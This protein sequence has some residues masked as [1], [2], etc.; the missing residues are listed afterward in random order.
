MQVFETIKATGDELHD[1]RLVGLAPRLEVTDGG[2]I[3]DPN[4]SRP[5]IFRSRLTLTADQRKHSGLR[6]ASFYVDRDL[7]GICQPGDRLHI[8]RTACGGLGL[9]LLR[10]DQLVVAVGAIAKVPLGNE[11][12]IET[13]HQRV[14]EAESI[15]RRDDP[16][17]EFPEFPVQISV[18]G[19][20][21]IKFRGWVRLEQYDMWLK[22]GFVPGVPGSDECAAILLRGGCGHATAI[23]SA[24]LLD[25]G[26]MEMV[27]W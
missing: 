9:S 3:P 24:Q 8:R 7:T 20:T 17:F 26:K 14:H 19:L 10:N 11:V 25:G 5:A 4:R 16:E 12:K 27:R 2:E 22:H 15:F 1:S 18:H 23:T 21:R 13:A 6:S